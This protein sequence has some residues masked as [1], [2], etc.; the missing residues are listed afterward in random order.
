MA[1]DGQETGTTSEDDGMGTPA[2]VGGY[3][4]KEEI[5]KAR[6]I[7]AELRRLAHKAIDQRDGSSLVLMALKLGELDD[8]IN[9]LD[10]ISRQTK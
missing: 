5:T 10:E 1:K 7:K 2:Q 4:W 9:R 6:S 3:D 8:V